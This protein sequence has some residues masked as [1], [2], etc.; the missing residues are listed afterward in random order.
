[1]KQHLTYQAD[2]SDD[3]VGNTR[4]INNALERIQAI[5]EE[6]KQ[7]LD[8][9]RQDLEAAQEEVKQPFPQEAEYV[10]K[11]E[12]LAQ[13]NIE[14]DHEE[15]AGGGAVQEEKESPARVVSE[16]P[17]LPGD[18]PSIRQAIRDYTPPTPGHPRIDRSQRREGTAL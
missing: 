15:H 16:A 2:L 9:L 10:A 14:L 6:E 3:A 4:R 5:L 12:R 1:M 8:T 7:S 11:S 13:L 18:K 17:V